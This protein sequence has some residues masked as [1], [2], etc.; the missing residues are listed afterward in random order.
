V[1]FHCPSQFS[2]LLCKCDIICQC[3]GFTLVSY[4]QQIAAI[5]DHAAT[6]PFELP[7]T[8]F[9][10]EAILE[11]TWNASSRTGGRECG[12]T[13]GR[14]D[15]PFYSNLA[16]QSDIRT[17]SLNLCDSKPEEDA[18][19]RS[20][21]ELN[22]FDPKDCEREKHRKHS[23]QQI[24]PATPAEKTASQRRVPHP[25]ALFSK[26]SRLSPPQ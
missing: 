14:I 22:N 17:I 4:P 26:T 5:C 2:H 16:T 19:L 12:R 8:L 20:I 9:L 3:N 1:I 23:V 10:K 18:E 13:G 11:I 24:R 7:P 6:Y 25:D 21:Y 15:G